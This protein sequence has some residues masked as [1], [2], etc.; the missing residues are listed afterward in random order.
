M[1]DG[2]EQFVAALAALPDEALADVL[3]RVFAARRGSDDSDGHHFLGRALFD[4]ES[5][6]WEIAT[7]AYPEPEEY[8]NSLGPDWGFR[9]KEISRIRELVEEHRQQ[10]L[11]SWDEFFRG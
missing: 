1:R 5:Q 8:G 9:R 10:L 7:V 6:K 4:S 3:R 2:H 11:E